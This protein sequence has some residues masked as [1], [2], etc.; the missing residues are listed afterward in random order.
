M[1][2]LI[3]IH[4]PMCS[5]C[6]A[7]R[8][9]LEELLA[10]LP[11]GMSYSRLLGGLAPDTDQPMPEELRNTLQATWRRIQ[12]K[13]PETR[14]NFDFWTLNTPRRSTYPACRAV[15]AARDLD[16]AKEEPMILAIQQAYYLQ[17]RNPSDEETLIAL[18][19]EI[20]LD[21][22]EFERT[23]Q[24]QVAQQ[25]L[26][27]EI[28]QATRLGVRSFPSLILQQDKSAW[29]VAVDYKAADN[30]LNTIHDILD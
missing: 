15:I 5:W 19:G 17:A 13:L 18:A 20:G 6:W 2:H 3:Y 14:F 29:P 28:A 9:V 30:I 7:F 11:N 24:S 1:T 10:R 27:T 23:L 4:D 21:A 16:A 26:E 22:I 8:P 25:T 12:E